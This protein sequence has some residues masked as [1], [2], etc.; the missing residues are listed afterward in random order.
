MNLTVR[1]AV[2]GDGAILHLM[3]QELAT[4]HG[5]A[6]D[7]SAVP[8]D[9]ERLLAD[10]RNITGALIA[11]AGGQPAGCAIW[12]WAFSTFQG[13]ET[14][15]LQDLCVLPPFRRQGI[16]QALLRATARLARGRNA[17]ALH[18]LMMGWNEEARRLYEAAGA[19][20]E[21]GNCFCILKGDALERL[22]T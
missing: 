2:P 9:F 4:H 17:A 20:V 8:E 1:T 11:E 21:G 22:A 5:H 3:V 18:W 10:S 14:V 15:Y 7:F 12:Q 13:R 19:E 16:G 6:A